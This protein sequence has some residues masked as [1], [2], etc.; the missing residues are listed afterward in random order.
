MINSS[1]GCQA[2]R[3]VGA[4]LL[5]IFGYTAT[6]Q[7]KQLISANFNVA[8]FKEFV[9]TVESQT[10][11][12][13]Y[14]QDKKLGSITI[15]ISVSHAHL[16]SVLDQVFGGS[17]WKYAID[18]SS[19]YITRYHPLAL[20]LPEGF[21]SGKPVVP[22]NDE[23]VQN[24]LPLNDKPNS[25][26]LEEDKTYEVGIKTN[27]QFNG[28]AN[29]AGYV[30]NASSGEGLSGVAVMLKD[31]KAKAVTDQFG[32]YSITLPEGSQ[33]LEFVLFGMFDTK[34]K[35]VLY[36]DGRLN[37]G[38]HEKIIQLKEVV[39]E[40]NKQRNVRNTSMGVER[41]SISAISQI[42]AVLGEVDVL[43][44]VISLPGVKS[45]G[46][47][48]TGLN[49]R[50]GAADQNLILFNDMN[51]YNPSHLFGFFSAVSSDVV[52]EVTLYKS[53]V[54][55]NYGGRL[56]SVLD[57]NSL[58]GNTNKLEGKAGIGLFTSKVSLNGPLIKDK[59][60]FV[61]SGR[62]TY[63]DWLLQLLPDE[64]K[65]GNGSFYDGTVH[66]SHKFSPDSRLYVNGYVSGDRFRLTRDTKNK[67][68][69]KNGNISWKKDMNNRLY[70]VFMI[71]AD[72]YDYLKMDSTEASRGYALSYALDQYK[73]SAGFNYYFN[74]D[75]TF[76]F[77]LEGK[78][79]QIH[80]GSL[81][82]SGKESLIMPDAL[83]REQ[84]L[85]SAIYFSD[86]YDIS[87]R[88]SLEGGARL[89][90]YQYLG[91]DEINT[92][93][94]GVP[95]STATIT[96]TE[97][98]TNLEVVKSYLRPNLRLS[99]RYLTS[100]NS[101]LKASYN[102]MHQ[103]IH[104][105][106]NTT[107]MSPTD[108]WKLSDSY[109]RPQV[110][111]QVSL[112][113]YRNFKS[114]TIETSIEIYYKWTK[115][116][117]DYKS[118][119][120]LVMNHHI[121]TDVIDTRGKAYGVELSIKKPTGKLNGWLGYT[122]SRTLIRQDDPLAGELINQGS[123]YPTNFDQPHNVN[124]VSNYKIN[125]RFSISVTGNYSTGR[126]IT[127][128]IAVYQYAGGER[129]L[130]SDR[131]AYR[132]PDYLRFDLSFNIEGNHKVHQPTHNSWSFGVYNLLGR[133]NAYSVFFTTED[134]NIQGYKLSIFGNLIPFVTYH[135]R[136]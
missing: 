78:L 53:S 129:L 8:S 15:T 74:N 125:H 34:R 46:E 50:G 4:L 97:Q 56:S 32:Y 128:P 37:V 113:Y 117:L 103:F 35:I 13:F 111:Q 84:A 120:Q 47:A 89:A 102:S 40:T 119:A 29:L 22:V 7:D 12:H 1:K 11:Y 63:S 16:P 30:R 93:A 85:Q 104:Q 106:S 114:N 14:F 57:I 96:G 126:P 70:G 51:I 95:K 75:H 124:L 90:L 109:L 31:G 71:G 123:Y 38:L 2:L 107:T 49:V 134:G 81:L 80:S 10:G 5:L 101:S 76:E 43:K 132:I 72:H 131:N 3:I 19:V 61:I 24:T 92:Y 94:P 121:E 105:L 58:D 25:K 91:P 79:Y 17:V 45:V 66:L 41:L 52:K 20:D 26:S 39:V 6:A 33:T 122:Y 21:F 116:Y 27:G 18:D 82:P 118:G 23:Q 36:S 112:G 136:F 115:H 65:D 69:N 86:K 64:Y 28:R 68:H 88:L 42:P 73:F 54:P 9:H 83:K 77:G 127:L 135:I 99:L 100:E 67:Y 98:Y 87:S 130:Y 133:R 110:G 48:S 55:A 60:T 62:A 108:I 44:A 59:T